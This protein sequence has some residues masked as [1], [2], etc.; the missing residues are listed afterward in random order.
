M[1]PGPRVP[2]V[3][4]HWF[5]LF[6]S[7]GVLCRVSAKFGLTF[8]GRYSLPEDCDAPPSTKAMGNNAG[9]VQGTR[10]RLH[11]RSTAGLFQAERPINKTTSQGCAGALPCGIGLPHI[12]QHAHRPQSL[13]SFRDLIHLVQAVLAQLLSGPFQ[14]NRLRCPCGDSS[15]FI[16]PKHLQCFGHLVYDAFN[17]AV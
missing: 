8:A 17:T 14:L 3:H 4:A 10:W 9:Y 12:P 13:A 11:G 16:S 1:T 5:W 6:L 7:V 2:S 15:I